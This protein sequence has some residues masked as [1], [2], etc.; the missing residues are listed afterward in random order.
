MLTRQAGLDV[1][2][3]V[4]AVP[5]TT[6][7]RGIPTEVLLNGDDCMPTEC[8]LSLD[9]VA[10]VR[11]THLTRRITTLRSARMVDVCRALS[12]ATDC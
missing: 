5:T 6:T 4:L 12:D 3:K 9:N 1:M 7:I 10:P 8:V 2:A 11:Q